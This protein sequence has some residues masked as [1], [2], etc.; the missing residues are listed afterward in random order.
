[1]ALL[2]NVLSAAVSFVGALLAYSFGNF[3]EG[4]IP[5]ALAMTAGFFIYIS[6][7]DIIPEIH[8]EKNRK[9]ALVKSTLLIAG[10]IIVYV[11]F[12]LLKEF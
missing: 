9:L 11:S 3:F 4:Y 1:M 6:T 10:V 5:I 12:A 7:S 8:E 2:I